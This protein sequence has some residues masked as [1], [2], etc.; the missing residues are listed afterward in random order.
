MNYHRVVVQ[1]LSWGIVLG[2][3]N[4]NP[5]STD[6]YERARKSLHFL[7]HCTAP[8]TGQLPNYGNN[9]GA[10]FF[11][12]SSGAYRDYRP[13]LSALASALKEPLVFRDENSE[14]EVAWYG[15]AAARTT[16]RK[17][18]RAQALS[19][20]GYY[21]WRENHT[22]TFIRCGHYRDRPGQADALHLD[23]WHQ[24]ENILRDAGTYRYNDEET[25]LRQFWGTAAHNTVTLGHYDQMQKGSRFIWYHWTTVVHAEVLETDTYWQFSGTINGFRQLNSDIQHQRIVRKYKNAAH[26]EVTDKVSGT[27]QEAL[28]QHW[29]PAPEQLDHLQISATDEQGEALEMIRRSAWYSSVY[30]HKI[31]SPCW[32][33]ST[34]GR[35]IV[36]TI[37]L[38]E[39]F[40]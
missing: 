39:L 16:G 17:V 13:Q 37:K 23:I 11:P 19:I 2:E 24:G 5:L 20:G 7:E 28:V 8:A 14:E 38:I 15:L 21:S 34:S 36:T 22:F 25:L 29:H 26:W 32:S 31:A 6:V 1:L 4:Q 18:P 40:C 30:G 12:L 10:L 27:F 33:F 3:K 35:T 9:D